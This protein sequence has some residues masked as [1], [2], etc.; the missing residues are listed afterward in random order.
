MY[1][2]KP[3]KKKHGDSQDAKRNIAIVIALLV[4]SALVIVLVLAL[5]GPTVGNVFSNVIDSLDAGQ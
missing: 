5:L 1:D 3:K 4:L 2:E